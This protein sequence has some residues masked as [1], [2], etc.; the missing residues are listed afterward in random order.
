MQGQHDQYDPL[1]AVTAMHRQMMAQMGMGDMFGGSGFSGGLDPFQ[2]MGGFAAGFGA[3]D[4]FAM[5]RQMMADHQRRMQLMMGG[6][7]MGMGMG[8]GLGL[9]FDGPAPALLQQ[10]HQLQQQYQQQQ[11]QQ[12]LVEEPSQERA[13]AEPYGQSAAHRMLLG[14]GAAPAFPS[15]SAA[16]SVAGPFPGAHTVRYSS[17]SYVSGPGGVR[18]TSTRG[19]RQGALEEVQHAY[20]DSA[21]G[22][23]GLLH[24]RGLGGRAVVRERVI[25]GASGRITAEQ[26]HFREVDP[27]DADAFNAAW[28]RRASEESA[29]LTAGATGAV[30]AAAGA[31]ATASVPALPQ[32]SRRDRGSAD[33]SNSNAH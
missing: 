33:Q 25:D 10:Q 7:G 24:G 32:P 30:G 31:A 27:A 20:S 17:S 21:S 18:Q 8:M 16:G 29:L 11:P 28:T 2:S 5:H 23:A 6:M 14:F 9:G 3:A 13:V 26:T 19:V 22:Q 15:P 4:P 1:N 12:P